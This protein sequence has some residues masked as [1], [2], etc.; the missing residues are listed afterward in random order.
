MVQC[1]LWEKWET[2]VEEGGRLS[3]PHILFCNLLFCFVLIMCRG[4]LFK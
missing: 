3:S 1:G 2:G 4:F